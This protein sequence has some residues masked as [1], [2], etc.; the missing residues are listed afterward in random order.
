MRM[1]D[2]EWL[3]LHFAERRILSH[4]MIAEESGIRMPT[5]TA[6]AIAPGFSFS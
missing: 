4:E 6:P 5:Q 2:T 3:N 1:Q